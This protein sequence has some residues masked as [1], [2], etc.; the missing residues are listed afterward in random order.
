MKNL[1]VKRRSF[2]ACMSGIFLILAGC[3]ASR[4]KLSQTTM[5]A[6]V[7][8]NN[9]QVFPLSAAVMMDKNGYATSDSV[10]DKYTYRIELSQSAGENTLDLSIMNPDHTTT[11]ATAMFTLTQPI[12]ETATSGTI[13]CDSNTEANPSAANALCRL[14]DFTAFEYRYPSSQ[15][16]PSIE[17]CQIKYKVSKDFVWSPEVVLS[18][19]YSSTQGAFQL[20]VTCKADQSA[21]NKAG[22]TVF[23]ATFAQK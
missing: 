19:V 14:E 16:T 23:K 4:G 5:S 1:K 11:V 15:G 12:F 13:Q 3:N 17:S 8:K 10:D 6:S 21:G 2:V 22:K 7:Q 9:G 20:T 18:S